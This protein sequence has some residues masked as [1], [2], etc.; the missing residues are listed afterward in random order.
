MGACRHIRGTIPAPI[1]VL[2]NNRHPLVG[3]GELQKLHNSGTYTHQCQAVTHCQCPFHYLGI[4]P[5]SET[6]VHAL[7][8]I[9]AMISELSRR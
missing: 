3:G 9:W 8:R 6:L 1:V 4:N 7:N 5:D 2:P